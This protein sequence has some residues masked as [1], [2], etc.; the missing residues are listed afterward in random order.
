MKKTLLLTLVALFALNL[1]G[2]KRALLP[3]YLRNHAV[4]A[5]TK[6][7][8]VPVSQAGSVVELNRS[9]SISEEEIGQTVYDSQTN[10][11]DDNRIYLYPDGTIGTT[12]T[13]GLTASA[14]AD[15]GAGYNYFDASVW[16]TIPTAR[17]ESIRTGWPSYS[18]WG[19]G[20]EVIVAHN[21]TQL[22]MSKRATKGT[23]TWTQSLIPIPGTGA[24]PTWP[25]VCTVG[26]TIHIL[27]A[28]DA[29]YQGQ[30]E[31]L[32]YYR[33]KDGGATWDKQGVIPAE[34][35]PAAGY[36]QG[37]GGDVYDWAEPQGNTIA[38]VVGSPNTNLVL[39]KSTDGGTTWVK[40][41]IFQHPYP[42]FV[43]G[44]DLIGDGVVNLDTPYVADGAHAISLDANGYA[45][46][47]FGLNRMLND[48]TTDA[49]CS[50]FPG[51]GGVAFWKEGDPAFTSANPDDIDAQ[52]KL[53]GYLQDLDGS[54]VVLDN[55]TSTSIGLY[56]VGTTSHPQITIGSD[57][58]IYVIFN[59]LVE[60]MMSTTSGQF[61]NHIYGRK[62]T[63]GGDTWTEFVDL[64][65]GS[66][67]ELVECAFPAMSKTE[68]GNLH[69]L[70][71]SDFEPGTSI[72]ADA[73]AA[74]TNSIMYL[75]VSSSEFSSTVLPCE[76]GN[77]EINLGGNINIYPN[78]V[79][80]NINVSFNFN[81][82]MSVNMTV[83]NSVGSVVMSNSFI[84]NGRNESNQ[85]NVKE[86]PTGIYLAKFETAKGT[87]NQKI[88]KQ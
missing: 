20:G 42:D 61:Y 79:N 40:T 39:M 52:C 75:Q 47:V 9:K 68:D 29:V 69:I 6:K 13:M 62:S 43:E 57:G 8:I 17:V 18:K 30:V 88:I 24:A 25:R 87:F 72:G 11:S 84:A 34:L 37:F 45:N 1:F 16:G 48:D 55:Y 19:T 26:D 54:G 78:P 28:D 22:V 56:G 51:V 86:L 38:F 46:V 32:F 35:S 76:V 5:Y 70:Y 12:W 27:A 21:G 60:T 3:A 81:K 58:A 10:A 66:D 82:S 73:D 2:Q 63:D 71:Q 15:R 31:P 53:I 74:G 64:T 77:K 83:F 14:Y 65:S 59:S 80:D 4:K 67:H 44:S 85:I 41:I 50:W 23:G 36:T 33:S 7:D 49:G